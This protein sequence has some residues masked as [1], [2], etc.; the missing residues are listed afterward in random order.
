MTVR[1]TVGR[2][3]LVSLLLVAACDGEQRATTCFCEPPGGTRPDDPPPAP[4][5][6]PPADLPARAACRAN[7]Q[8]G[9]LTSRF[10][11]LLGGEVGFDGNVRALAFSESSVYGLTEQTAFRASLTSRESQVRSVK[12]AFDAIVFTSA[13]LAMPVFV[14]LGVAALGG[15]S[16]EPG[17]LLRG[18]GGGEA[19]R[20]DDEVWYW[21]LSPARVGVVKGGVDR[22]V[23]SFG[24]GSREIVTA[25]Q[26]AGDFAYFTVATP[27]PERNGPL[28]DIRVRRVLRAGGV[29]SDVVVLPKGE[30]EPP[31]GVFAD[32]ERLYV[33]VGE[34]TRMFVFDFRTAQLTTRAFRDVPHRTSRVAFDGSAFFWGERGAGRCT[35]AVR[36][37]GKEPL[38]GERVIEGLA[39][40]TAVALSDGELFAS[41]ID[42]EPPQGGTSELVSW[43]P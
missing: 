20:V 27:G 3:A 15:S 34:E 32:G 16:S 21:T 23:A 4:S 24:A 39:R 2:L 6:E 28:E 8:T 40:V 26:V 9:T 10:V 29:P 38:V 30:R 5:F 7:A 1:P 22:T 13:S 14:D 35:G 31:D 36:R 19:I 37:V 18:G 11:G 43:R 25:M 33:A 17:Y 41:H 42:D 12:G